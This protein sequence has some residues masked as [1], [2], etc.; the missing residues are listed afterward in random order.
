MPSFNTLINQ[1][2]AGEA[3]SVNFPVDSDSDSDSDLELP[4]TQIPQPCSTAVVTSSNQENDVRITEDRKI[5]VQPEN[6]IV[7]RDPDSLDGQISPPVCEAFRVPNVGT[8]ATSSRLAIASGI[9]AAP[10]ASE[11]SVALAGIISTASGMM[12]SASLTEKTAR[13]RSRSRM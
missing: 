11:A 7:K 13:K 1:L 12:A 5:S 3:Q 4:S 10:V 9:A 2:F 8:V 6:A